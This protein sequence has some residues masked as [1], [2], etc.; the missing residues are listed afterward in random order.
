[1][2]R[3]KLED[4][5]A[6]WYLRLQYIIKDIEQV[7]NNAIRFIAKLKGRDSITAA[8]D[9]LNLET[10]HDRRFKLRHKLLL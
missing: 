8:R 10:L 5:A 2:S 4:A 6:I 3:P 9:K 1:M 7:Q